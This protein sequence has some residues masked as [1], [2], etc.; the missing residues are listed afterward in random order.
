EA[1]IRGALDAINTTQCQPPL[2]QEEVATIAASCATYPAGQAREDV[3][4][5]HNGQ[6]QPRQEPHAS[7][8]PISFVPA[9]LSFQEL[10]TLAIPERKRY[11]EWLPERGIV[12]VYGPRGAGKTM[13]MLGLTVALTTGKPFLKWGVPHATGVLYVD[14]EMPLVELRERAV[15]MTQHAIPQ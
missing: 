8:Q 4:Q 2:A 6:A 10:L 1:A 12:M 5:R 13:F 15:L 9:L 14:G 3:H 7:Q 11:V